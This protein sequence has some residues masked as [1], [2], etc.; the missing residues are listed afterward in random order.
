MKDSMGWQLI[1][2]SPHMEVQVEHIAINA[3]VLNPSQD[4]SYKMVAASEANLI[5]L[6]S[7]SDDGDSREI[8][9][10]RYLTLG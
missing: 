6:W 3:K 2:T 10:T 5:R 7:V 4:N 8:G 9:T 1:W